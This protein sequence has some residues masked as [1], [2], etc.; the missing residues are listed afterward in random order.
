VKAFGTVIARI[1]R[2]SLRERG[3]MF[4][5]A[6]ALLSM[7]WNQFLMRPLANRRTAIEHSLGDIRERHAAPDSGHG[8]D[9][10]A[11]RY[12][13]QKLR[14]AALGAAI[15][16]ADTQLREAQAGMIAPKEMLGVLTD[17]LGHQQGLTL[18]QL[19][20]LAVEPLL[21]PAGSAGSVPKAGME[22][23]LHPAELILRGDYLNVLAYL[24]E[25][26]SRSWGFQWRRFE[27]TTTDGGPEYRIEFTTLSMQP[28]W[29]GV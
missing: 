8:L 2:A 7:L 29:L 23:Y 14:E 4:L 20:N 12:A 27:L 13:A 1:N 11:D 25:L 18:V 28:N 19:R 9:S 3:L 22:P 10:L 21:T 24:K 6:M 5:A 17:V 26:E 15:A 16:D